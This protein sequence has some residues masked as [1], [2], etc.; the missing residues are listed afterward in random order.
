MRKNIMAEQDIREIATLTEIVKL[1][2]RKLDYGTWSLIAGGAETGTTLR[3]NRRALDSLALIPRVLRDVRNVDASSS[4]LGL[5]QRIPVLLAP[6]GP[7]VQMDREGVM[8]VVGAGDEFGITTII[9]SSAG[10][11]MGTIC[12]KSNM[13]LIYQ[14]Y[15]TGDDGWLMDQVDRINA[16]GYAALC[17]TVDAATSSRNIEH[18]ILRTGDPHATANDESR[19]GREFQAA[20][21]WRHVEMIRR[22]SRI[23]LILKGISALE[24][25]GMAVDHGVDS[26]FVSNHGGRQLDHAPGTMELL[27]E[28]VEHAGDRV[29]IGIDGGFMRGTDIVKAIA[30]GANV[31]GI[32]K[33]YCYGLAAGGE[34]GVI[35][36]L[37]LLE[38]EIR[39][40]MGLL[41]VTALDQLTPEFL[42]RSTP[43]GRPGES[44]AFPLIDPADEAGRSGG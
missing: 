17:L 34:A 33:L 39:N 42:R 14:L 7:L 24:D 16:S 23:P 31:V 5:A 12:R 15:I 32:G 8:A 38:K 22:R 11:E 3:R 44:S 1:A 25:A 26:I 35:R 21:S 28:I 4:Y 18:G 43:V 41:G 20:L 10:H 27:P 19:Y 40:A 6:V 36:V 2:R 9:S 30:A 37:E 13:P 29:E